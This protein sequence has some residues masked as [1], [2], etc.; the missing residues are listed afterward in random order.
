MSGEDA[1]EFDRCAA[2]YDEQRPIDDAWWEVYDRLVALG[3]LRG[4][5]VLELGCGTGRLSQALAERARARVWAVDESEEM[6]RQARSRDVNARVAR[7][8]RLPFRAGWFDAVVMRMALHL[9]DGPRALAQAARVLAP[10]GRIVIATEDPDRFDEVWFARYFPSVPEIDRGRFPDATA[11]ETQ[12]HAVGMAT[13]R[14]ERLGQQRTIT[15]ERALDLIS[16]KAYSTFARIAPEEYLAGLARAEAEL[17]GEFDYR[18]DWL[19][20]AGAR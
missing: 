19:L 7:A 2:R 16:S 8:E 20:V 6:V 5:R 9:F 13:V 14:I 1:A 12:L 3:E 17:P 15:R 10:D 11:L 18:F 4:A